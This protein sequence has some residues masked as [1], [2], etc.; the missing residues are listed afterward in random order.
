MFLQCFV[1]VLCKTRCFQVDHIRISFVS[2]VCLLPAQKKARGDH[3]SRFFSLITSA[4][5]ES[6][7]VTALKSS[8]LFPFGFDFFRKLRLLFARKVVPRYLIGVPTTEIKIL[9]VVGSPRP[10]QSKRF[11]VPCFPRRRSFVSPPLPS[12]CSSFF[13]LWSASIVDV[14]RVAS[15]FC[16]LPKVLPRS[17]PRRVALQLDCRWQQLHSFGSSNELASE[18]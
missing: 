7:M 10:T 8:T 6:M 2:R 15:S 14:G 18:E 3:R 9:H 5:L 17:C 11:R 16:S 12:G 1:H 13:L 4:C